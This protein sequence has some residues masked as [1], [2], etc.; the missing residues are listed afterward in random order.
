MTVDKILTLK[1]SQEEEEKW[2][3]GT[4]WYQRQ[5]GAKWYRLRKQPMETKPMK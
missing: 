1:K 3:H 4:E 5:K 2:Y